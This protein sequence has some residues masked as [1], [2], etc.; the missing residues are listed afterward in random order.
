MAFDASI[1]P[2]LV[3]LGTTIAGSVG[4][5]KKPKRTNVGSRAAAKAATTLSNAAVGGAQ[6]G[7]GASRGLAL[8][9]GLRGAAQVAGDAS[10]EVAQA[11]QVDE[12]NYQGLLRQRNEDVAKF[13]SGIGE[14]LA[15]MG[16]SFIQP[17]MGST[18]GVSAQKQAENTLPGAAT[19]E[20]GSIVD[21]EVQALQQEV[22]AVQAV[23]D[24]AAAN[25]P[26]VV[27]PT[28]Q[29]GSTKALEDL[30]TRAPTVAAPEI[31]ADLE[32]RLQA[33]KLMLQDAERLGY[34]LGDITASINR[35]FGLSPGQ[36]VDNPF[37]V[38]L[39]MG[40]E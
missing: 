1:I 20:Q 13:T 10:A 29:F 18:D 35:R 21:P 3:G 4:K 37:G 6:A 14:G 25:D 2:S 7:H 5:L 28:A 36:S 12:A 16:Q 9:E 33:K 24:Q 8:R 34:N 40:N 11:A 38:R 39:D 17:K 23:E 27:G 31:E 32:N 22:G 15:Q 19:P 30:M 26:S